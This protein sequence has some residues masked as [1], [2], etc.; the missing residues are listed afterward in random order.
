MSPEDSE[1]IAYACRDD[2]YYSNS[3]YFIL[4]KDGQAAIYSFSHC[5]CYGTW[6]GSGEV[7]SG[8]VE[9]LMDMAEHKRD[10]AMPAREVVDADYDSAHI[11]ECYEQV[12]DWSKTKSDPRTQAV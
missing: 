5:S 8:T 3:G 11:R 4:V 10:P 7:W 12:I 2:Q 6:E 1:Q 9:E